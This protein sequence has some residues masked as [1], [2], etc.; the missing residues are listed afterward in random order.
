MLRMKKVNEDAMGGVSAPM[1]TLNNTPGVGNAVPASS[2]ATTGAQQTSSS[3]I[4]SGD[5]WRSAGTYTQ[6]KKLK[7]KKKKVQ[8]DSINPY[9]KIG[10]AMAKKLKVPMPFKKKKSRT[11]T[12]SQKKFESFQVPTDISH[13]LKDDTDY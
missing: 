9:D 13:Y 11:N 3:S 7:K 6:N 4:G 5:K 12:V 1:S 2:A 10:T 8:E